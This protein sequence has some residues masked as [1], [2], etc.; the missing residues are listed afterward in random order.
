MSPCQSAD[1]ARCRWQARFLHGDD[2][3]LAV[4]RLR[5]N[6]MGVSS[7]Q[8]RWDHVKECLLDVKTWIWFCLLTAVS[9]P[10]G[11]ISTFGPL[12]VEAFGFDSFTTILFNMPVILPSTLYSYRDWPR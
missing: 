12:I 4:E 5:M 11:G 8:W 10:S 3:L 6:Q 1:V 2:K 7:G 9:I